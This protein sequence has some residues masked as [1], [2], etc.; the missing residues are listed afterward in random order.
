ML[1][2]V[3]ASVLVPQQLSHVCHTT[4]VKLGHSVQTDHTSRYLV[5]FARPYQLRSRARERAGASGHH[6][7]RASDVRHY[8]SLEYVSHVAEYVPATDATDATRYN[9][10]ENATRTVK[11]RNVYRFEWIDTRGISR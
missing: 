7:L 11:K 6:T 2:L 3:R 8:A 4:L 5:A 1:D 10:S 9:G